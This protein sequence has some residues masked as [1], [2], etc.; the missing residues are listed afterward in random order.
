MF[1]AQLSKITTWQ[2]NDSTQL[3][4]TKNACDIHIQIT[5]CARHKHGILYFFWNGNGAS[6][7]GY[8][9]TQLWVFYRR[10]TQLFLNRY[11]NKI[12]HKILIV[13]IEFVSDEHAAPL[14]T[15][16]MD[17]LLQDL[18]KSRSREIRVYTFLIAPNLTG[19]SPSGL[20]R[21]MFDFRDIPSLQRPISQLRD[22]T[23]FGD[24]TYYRLGNRGPVYNRYLIDV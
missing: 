24:K 21:C 12:V 10:L 23:R 6:F 15:N 3:S 20:P 19:T 8:F 9:L 14:F 22:F 2:A 17:V 5:I 11:V 18:M 13:Q 4:K 16:R 7:S 1:I